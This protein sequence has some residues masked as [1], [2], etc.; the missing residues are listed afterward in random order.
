MKT[1]NLLL[2]LAVS[3]AFVSC[4]KDRDIVE[5]PKAPETME[6]LQVPAS[7]NWKTTKN[8][9]L[10]LTAPAAGIAEVGNTSGA[11][12]MKA[13]LTAN[14]PYTMKLTVPTYET[15]VKLRFGAKTADLPLSSDVLQ[16]QF[17]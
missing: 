7:F 13:Y 4:R 5:E 2:I 14:Q 17:Q 1:R 16:F 10:T 15:A 9:S 12:Y 3:F 6:E 11:V 8:I